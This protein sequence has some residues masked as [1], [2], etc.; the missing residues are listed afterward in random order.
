MKKTKGTWFP[1]PVKMIGR[2]LTD[3]GFE[4]ED[5]LTFTKGEL[6]LFLNYYKSKIK[7]YGK[8]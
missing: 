1:N 4:K 3:D 2:F 5:Y 6:K 7:K 8:H